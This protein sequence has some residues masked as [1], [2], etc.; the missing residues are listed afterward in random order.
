MGVEEL[1]EA[2]KQ[3]NVETLTLVG[4]TDPRGDHL[5]NVEL[6]KRRAAAVR[7]YL[8]SQGVKARILVDGRGPD[9]PF[10]VSLLGRTVSQSE[11]LAL[12]RRVEWVR[13]GEP[14]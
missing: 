10:D 8:L 14:D 11:A 5:Y 9:E 6:S 12:D 13:K 1:A 3:Q 4:H 7:D 2:V